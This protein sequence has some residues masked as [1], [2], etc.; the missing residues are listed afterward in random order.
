MIRSFHSISA[1][2]GIALSRSKDRASDSILLCSHICALILSSAYLIFLISRRSLCLLCLLYRCM[3]VLDSRSNCFNL[4]RRL[5]F[6]VA[7]RSRLHFSEGGIGG[8]R[9]CGIIAVRRETATSFVLSY[10]C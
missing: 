10:Q 5:R 3:A 6:I 1:W 8:G 4:R 7:Q 9:G 2:D